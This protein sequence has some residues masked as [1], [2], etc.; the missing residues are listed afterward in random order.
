MRSSRSERRNPIPQKSP[1]EADVDSEK[2]ERCPQET[3]GAL[4]TD[5]RKLSARIDSE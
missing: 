1:T 4:R 2:N 3:R 5:R